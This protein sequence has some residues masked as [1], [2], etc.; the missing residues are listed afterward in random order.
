MNQ[1]ARRTLLILE[2]LAEQGSSSLSRLAADLGLN[3]ST[4]YRFVATLVEAGYVRQDPVTQVYV[5]TTKLAGLGAQ[6]LEH[7][8][9][10]KEVRPYL[11]R[12]AA[13]SAE[14]AHLAILDDHEIAYVD[15]VEGRQA[16]NMTSRVG[17]RGSAHS[18]AL[19]KVLLAACSPEEQARY[20]AERGLPRR[21]E[22]T[23]VDSAR[24]LRE[25]KDV[26]RRGYAVDDIENEAGIRCVAGPILDHTGEV[27]AAMSVSGW[28]VS[29][30]PSRIE[31]L[32]PSVVELAGEASRALGLGSAQAQMVG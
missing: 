25:L 14:T 19:G 5:L 9:I 27:V 16:V 28:T 29:M 11:E 20:L 31:E 21:T 8:E 7:I 12:L 4:A 10:R 1:S 24:F 30:T 32:I 2:H 13:V 6:V 26:R 15:K 17:G 23:I 3:K 22:N 18:T